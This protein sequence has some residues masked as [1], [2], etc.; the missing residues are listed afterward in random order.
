[1]A[2]S[3]WTWQVCGRHVY[4][5]YLWDIPCS[6]QRV[7]GRLS[8]GKI[9]SRGVHPAVLTIDA[10]EDGDYARHRSSSYEAG[11]HSGMALLSCDSFFHQPDISLLLLDGAALR[12]QRS[13]KNVVQLDLVGYTI[14]GVENTE[15]VNFCCDT[16]VI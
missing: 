1:M 14:F 4:Q 2:R 7:S 9:E 15:A 12:P 11:Q 6:C 5:E 13:L 3:N 16:W 10:M 8:T